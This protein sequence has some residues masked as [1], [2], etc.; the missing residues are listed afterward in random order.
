MHFNWLRHW[1]GV[2]TDHAGAM[3]EAEGFTVIRLL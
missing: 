1:F 3:T 2:L